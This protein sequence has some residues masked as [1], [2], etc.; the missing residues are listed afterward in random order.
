MRNHP[1]TMSQ[2]HALFDEGWARGQ[3][4]HAKGLGYKDCPYGDGTESARSRRAGWRSG[5]SS[6]QLVEKSR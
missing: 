6:Q 5:W 4:D 2:H 3:E 1:L